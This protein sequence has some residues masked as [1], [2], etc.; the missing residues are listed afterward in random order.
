MTRL[1][2]LAAV[3]IALGGSLVQAQTPSRKPEPSAAI[4]TAVKEI[5][6]DL[7]EARE[8]LKKVTDKAAR[9][10]L[11]LLITR[12][13]LRAVEIE[14][15]LVDLPSAELP[16]PLSREEFAKLL[17]SLKAE[18]FDDGKASFVALFATKGR[19]TSE[20]AREILKAFS[21]DDDRVKT[22]VILYPRLTDPENF[23]TLLDVFSFPSSREEV[24]KKLKAQ[25]LK[26]Q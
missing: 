26:A 16:E 13:E 24:R 14:R 1:I 17:K 4:T 3:L 10:R 9:E 23:F 6:A 25:K 12:T 8:L 2:T 19:L 7:R 15:A 20:Q 22:A 21:F 11:E 18:S 5:A